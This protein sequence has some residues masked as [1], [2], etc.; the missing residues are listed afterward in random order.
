MVVNLHKYCDK[1]QLT[2]FCGR[3][4]LLLDKTTTVFFSF[5]CE[6]EGNHFI[7]GSKLPTAYRFWSGCVTKN[8][9]IF[10]SLYNLQ[11]GKYGESIQ[12]ILFRDSGQLVS[13][14]L[15]VNFQQF[16]SLFFFFGLL[17]YV[18]MC[19]S[20][21]LFREARTANWCFCKY[22][23]SKNSV[24]DM[25]E[26]LPWRRWSPNHPHYCAVSKQYLSL[27]FGHSTRKSV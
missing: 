12:S 10:H 8:A 21:M 6:I 22:G 2:S 27:S 11:W 1:K 19:T 14:L 18:S 3:M 24:S 16:L 13:L 7:F 26:L 25:D 5:W 17:A 23:E 15:E 9:H 20:V 4:W